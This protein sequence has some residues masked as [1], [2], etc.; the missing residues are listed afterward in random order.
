[1][2]LVLKTLIYTFIQRN[3]KNSNRQNPYIY[4]KNSIWVFFIFY[5]IKTVCNLYAIRMQQSYHL[6]FSNMQQ[7]KME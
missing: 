6:I 5:K 4:G 7:I 3:S 2:Q 1:M